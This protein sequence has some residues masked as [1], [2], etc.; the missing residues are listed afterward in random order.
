M[1]NI[2]EEG[3]K[4]EK[5]E[6]EERQYCEEGLEQEK[7]GGYNDRRFGKGK[8]EKRRYSEKELG[9]RN[10]LTGILSLFVIVGR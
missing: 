1:K 2:S 6:E 4:F 9:Q 3:N 7:K 10:R 8:K 5:E